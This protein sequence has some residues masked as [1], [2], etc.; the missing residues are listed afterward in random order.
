MENRRRSEAIPSF[1]ARTR[2]E[3]SNSPSYIGDGSYGVSEDQEVFPSVQRL[4]DMG[5]RT[6]DI[7][8]AKTKSLAAQRGHSRELKFDLLSNE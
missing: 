1:F 6:E 5:E 4:S 8:R 7:R 2:Y 3:S